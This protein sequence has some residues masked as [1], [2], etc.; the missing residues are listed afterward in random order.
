MN[1]ALPP[2]IQPCSR[3]ALLKMSTFAA[4]AAAV[5]LSGCQ[6]QTAPLT[7]YL[8]ERAIPATLLKA[9]SRQF[10][11]ANLE[12]KAQISGLFEQLQRFADGTPGPTLLSLGD[13]WL[14]AAIQNQLIRPLS[15]AQLSGW[16]RLPQAWQQLVTRNEVGEVAEAGEIWGAPYR[17]GQLV[18][19]YRPERIAPDKLPKDWSDLWRGDLAGKVT[20]LDS[21][22]TVIGLVLQAMGRDP[23]TAALD[24]V[25]GL[26]DRLTALHRQVRLYSSQAYL[27]PLI[28][29]DAWLAVGWSTDILPLARRNPRLAIAVPESG[30]LTTSDVWVQPSAADDSELTAQWIRFFWQPETAVRFSLLGSGVSPILLGQPREDLPLGLQ[31]DSALLPSQATIQRSAALLPLAPEV[32]ERYRALWA[33]TRREAASA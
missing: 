20:M 13:Y 26:A 17:T 10:G 31:T 8:L 28:I 2:Q 30:T 12:R 23:N 32:A 24:Q 6:S 15:E 4:L 22:R 5:S 18:M 1:K 33:S 29:E 9:F 14:Q 27:Q 25:P 16:S 19:L 11:P 21:A 7:V 3:R